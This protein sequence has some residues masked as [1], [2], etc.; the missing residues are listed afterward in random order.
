[1]HFLQAPFEQE[2]NVYFGKQKIY[3]RLFMLFLSTLDDYYRPDIK[4][5]ALLY[6]EPLKQMKLFM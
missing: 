5:P 6:L 4:N 1:M 2:L 3:I